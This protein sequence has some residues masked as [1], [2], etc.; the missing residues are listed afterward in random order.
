VNVAITM[1]KLTSGFVRAKKSGTAARSVASKDDRALGL[2]SSA[3]V[4]KP[5]I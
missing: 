5:G 1:R 3:D 2:I 4:D